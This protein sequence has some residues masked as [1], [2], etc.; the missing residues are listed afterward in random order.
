[1]DADGKPSPGG[2]VLI[3][4]QT[5]GEA[6]SQRFTLRLARDDYY[7]LSIAGSTDCVDIDRIERGEGVPLIRRPCSGETSQGWYVNAKD[8]MHELENAYS[9]KCADVEQSREG[10][11]AFVHQ[12]GCFGGKNQSWFLSPLTP[13]PL[14]TVI[15]DSYEAS[16]WIGTG[17]SQ[18]TM[19]PGP[20]GGS[21]DCE[22]NRAPNARG[23]CHTV[24][25]D[26]FG[27]GDTASGASWVY[28]FDNYGQNPGPRIA[29][30][31]QRIRFQA[32][33]ERGAEKVSFSAGGNA[34]HTFFDTFKTEPLSVELSTEWRSYSLNLAG[35]DY[36]NGVVIAFEWIIELSENQAPF[37]FYVDD[38]VWE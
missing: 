33:G 13:L 7:T 29:A 1:M 20:N 31:A 14:P 27:N 5:C 6:N 2:N 32:R 25:L 10:P 4:Q 34:E 36:A 35:F 19:V 21:R 17:I 23:Y 22:G 26:A 3:E 24:T 9:A 11:G 15:D 30:G 38:I 8:S 16:P 18:P 28:P 12:W 37:R